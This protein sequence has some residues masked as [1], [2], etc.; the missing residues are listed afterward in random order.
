MKIQALSVWNSTGKGRLAEFKCWQNL[1]RLFA[2]SDLGDVMKKKEKAGQHV[3][4]KNIFVLKMSE[5]FL[6]FITQ[7]CLIHRSPRS[8]FAA[9]I[10]PQKISNVC[11]T[12]V[13]P[14]CWMELVT[15][16][17]NHK[18]ITFM[19]QT[20]FDKF[21]FDLVFHLH[22]GDGSEGGGWRRRMH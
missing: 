22:G 4:R 8:R 7:P 20:P 3:S 19:G 18:S 17:T 1:G 16:R 9:K 13:V 21:G 11:C 12:L 5:E 15:T 6:S 14:F 2:Y 10:S